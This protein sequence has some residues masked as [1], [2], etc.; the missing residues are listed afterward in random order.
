MQ[1]K[2]IELS[3]AIKINQNLGKLD[4]YVKKERSK[5]K[6]RVADKKSTTAVP[7]TKRKKPE[8]YNLT[9]HCLDDSNRKSIS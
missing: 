6:S 2:I 7:C 4:K 9:M 5:S 8:E 1:E 3:K